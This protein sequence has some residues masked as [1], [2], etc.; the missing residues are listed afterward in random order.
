MILWFTILFMLLATVLTHAQSLDQIRKQFANPPKSVRPMVRWWWPGG[1]VT[2]DELRRE[3]GILD[4]AGFGG[5][6]IQAFRIGLKPDMPADALARLN[7][8]PTVSFYRKVGAALEEAT[9]RGLFVDMTLGSGWPFGGGEAIT[10]ELATLEL[11]S[12]SRTVR[13]PGRFT[14]RLV[15]PPAAPG[16]AEMIA[17]MTGT[18]L[19]LPSGWQE[20]LEARKRPVAVVAIRG[21]APEVEESRSEPFPMPRTVVKTPGRLDPAS[22]VLLTDKLKDD[23]TLD[24]VAP[25]GTWQLFLFAQQPGSARVIGG[26]GTGPQLVLDH[27]NRNALEAHLNRIGEPAETAIGKYFGKGL[28]AVFCDSLEVHAELFWSDTFLQEFR[29]LRGYDL[30]PWLPFLKVPGTGE[31]YGG[32]D[33][34]PM[35]DGEGAARVRRDYWHTV[36]DLWIDNFFRPLRD[37]AH[38]RGLLARV[39]AHGAPADT[40]RAYGIA[41]IPETEQLFAGGSMPFLKAASSAA[42]IY[43]RRLVSAEAFVRMGQAYKTTA[44]SLERDTNTLIAAG[45]NQIIYHGFPYEYMDR[46]EPGWHPFASPLPFSDHF[47]PRNTKIW[48]EIPRMNGYISRLQYIAQNGKRIVRYAVYRPELEYPNRS[49]VQG[50]QSLDWDFISEHAL[51]QSRVRDGK[52]VTPGGAEY[53]ALIAPESAE[54]RRRFPGVKVLP[55]VPSGEEEPVRWKLGDNEFIF[56]FNP[57]SAAKTVKLPAG[58]WEIW[59]AFTGTVAPHRGDTLGLAGGAAK[60]LRRM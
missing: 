20:R 37:W 52:L 25:E 54:L 46:P 13:G 35:F 22:A 26:V 58:A 9:K 32:W 16:F 36:S 45:I 30:T 17:K 47:N 27:M 5:A 18:S 33:S 29:R 34:P 50:P 19:A 1:D 44:E 53:E 55:A 42:Q 31:P 23:G 11:R 60:L 49:D 28:R 15:L 41:D 8:Y 51:G 10:P 7:D 48:S 24:W 4:E 12:V 3:V 57:S 6:E 14:D 56:C 38:R 21:T 2:P 59:D 43:G 40:L 39:Q